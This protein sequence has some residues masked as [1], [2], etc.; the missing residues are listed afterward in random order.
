MFGALL[1]FITCKLEATFSSD[2]I[3]YIAATRPI[4]YIGASVLGRL[5]TLLLQC[6]FLTVGR[7]VPG[8][9]Y[10]HLSYHQSRIHACR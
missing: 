9:S 1:H 10:S 2:M 5:D 6:A 3:G 7:L 4:G 8:N